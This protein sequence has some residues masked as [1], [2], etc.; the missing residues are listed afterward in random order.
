[1]SFWP[2]LYLHVLHINIIFCQQKLEVL[3]S[4]VA[5]SREGMI[6]VLLIP[7]GFIERQVLGTLITMIVVCR[8]LL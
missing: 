6:V 1:M 7:R 8:I 4:L 2:L 3:M 5:A